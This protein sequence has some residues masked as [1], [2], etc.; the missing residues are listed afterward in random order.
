MNLVDERSPAPGLSAVA[1][2][3]A[4]K[5]R[6]RTRGSSLGLNLVSIALGIAIWEPLARLG[7]RLPPP[8]AVARG[9]GERLADG[10]LEDDIRASLTRVVT[11]FALG[12][13]AA[14]P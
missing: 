12:V 2:P 14:V 10:S 8:A 6:F 13:A 9:A 7:S 11:G 4:G 1:A 3:A 5:R